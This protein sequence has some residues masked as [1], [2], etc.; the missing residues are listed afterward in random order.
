MSACIQVLFWFEAF[1]REA[2]DDLTDK[3]AFNILQEQQEKGLIYKEEMQDPV[4][5]MPLTSFCLW[6]DLYKHHIKYL[7]IYI[8]IYLCTFPSFPFNMEVQI[9]VMISPF[10]QNLIFVQVP[11]AFLLLWQPLFGPVASVVQWVAPEP[12]RG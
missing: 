11:L 4:I 2:S 6:K 3:S 1:H 5:E 7:Y 9:V 12:Q 8:I 10:T